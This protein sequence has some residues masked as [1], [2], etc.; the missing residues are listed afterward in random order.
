MI[1][2]TMTENCLCCSGKLTIHCCGPLLSQ[3]KFAKTPVQLMR[4]RYSAYA[5]GGHGDYLLA[6]WLPTMTQG[7]S[8]AALSTRTL[9]WVRLE[10][11]NKSQQGDNGHVEFKAY[12][13][14]AQAQEE[15][16]HEK[17]VFKRLN[18]RW[19]YVGGEVS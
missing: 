7:L 1:Q 8:S 13:L 18:G 6:T 2:T 15:V 5:L 14:N 9:D 10:I 3:T 12:F 11:I 4:S 16:Q 17:S 19:Y